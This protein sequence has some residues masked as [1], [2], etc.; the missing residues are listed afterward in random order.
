[1]SAAGV[2]GLNANNNNN[3]SSIG[4]LSNCSINNNNTSSGGGT[5]HRSN[6][7]HRGDNPAHVL[8][9]SQSMTQPSRSHKPPV[10]SASMA[11][12]GSPF[13]TS[14][15]SCC[16]NQLMHLSLDDSS[17]GAAGGGGEGA[18]VRKSRA[19][20]MSQSLHISSGSR[21]SSL[22]K[23][24]GSGPHSSSGSNGTHP[25][26]ESANGVPA[27]KPSYSPMQ[28]LM[29]FGNKLSPYEYREILDYKRIYFIGNAATAATGANAPEGT[30][31]STTNG[32]GSNGTHA[33]HSE[34][35]AVAA[36]VSMAEKPPRKE[37]EGSEGGPSAP[38][39]GSAAEKRKSQALENFTPASHDHVAYRYVNITWIAAKL[40]R[41]AKSSVY[42]KD[43]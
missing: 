34:V 28:V 17:G 20:G 6:G 32:N 13:C 16:S 18:H 30:T 33:G 8:Y 23:A 7:A 35:V 39:D 25:V 3:S 15:T 27:T 14:A 38:A 11:A 43:V 41:P 2:A 9:H 36:A 12:K 22:T 1:M 10:N 24:V 29:L 5:D 21:N 40:F 37:K 4:N 19:V 31:S 42:P 26:D